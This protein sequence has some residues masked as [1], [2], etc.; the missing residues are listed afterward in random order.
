MSSSNPINANGIDI[1]KE[2]SKLM[3]EINKEFNT[4]IKPP[5]LG[6]FFTWELLEFGTSIKYFFKKFTDSERKKTD[7]KNDEDIKNKFFIF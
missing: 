7:I 1:I 4:K 2:I 3:I 5:P 6:F